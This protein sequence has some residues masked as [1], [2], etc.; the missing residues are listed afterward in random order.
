MTS[1]SS[2]LDIPSGG[3]KLGLFTNQI[4]KFIIL[5]LGCIF[6]VF[7]GVQV[8]DS[9]A[10]GLAILMRYVTAATFITA[11]ISPRLGIWLVLLMCPGLD[12][13]KR[14]LIL[15][16]N[17]N[18]FDVASVLAIAPVTMA[19]A[20]AGTF[21]NRIV[22][23]R[24]AAIPGEQTL[25]LILLA[26]TSLIV[27]SGVLHNLDSKLTLM[28]NL[29]EAC[30][31]LC[32]LLLIPVY[33]PKTEQVATLLRATVLIFIPVAFYGF[34]Q[35]FAGLSDFELRYLMSGLT[36]TAEDYMNSG[37]IFSSLNSNHSFSVTMAC[38]S[39]ISLLQRQLPAAGKWQGFMKRHGLL[40]FT[41]FCA[42]AIISLR[43]T[44]WLVVFFSL[45]GAI[46]FRTRLRTTVFYSLCLLGG[47]L[48]IFNAES[49]YGY[50]PRW[51]ASLQSSIPGYDQAF[52]LQT[53]NDRL[54]SFQTLTHSQNIWSPFGLSTEQREAI[55]VHDAISETLVSYG[56]IGLLAFVTVLVVVLGA[57]HRLV[58]KA[59]NPSDQYYA[60]L[61]L[62]FIFANLFVGA[63]MQSHINIF[64][65]NFIF[66]MCAGAL[67]KITFNQQTIV[68]VKPKIDP[69]ALAAAI[70]AAR[71]P[72]TA[73]VMGGYSL[74]NR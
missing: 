45:A 24:Q 25:F 52:Q 2:A 50:L 64:P 13:V 67:L 20:V 41:L 57:S 27:T 33:F 31:Y 18:M 62:S 1:T 61:L 21:F 36:V 37:R 71:R 14:F 16:S 74:P 48:I 46:C 39:V 26:I 43:R 49:I 23:R 70:K 38:C 65:V 51:E 6:S 29:A 15:F 59:T 63:I 42:A 17:V 72:V 55:F 19:G 5:G 44:G 60:S 73:T 9:D 68:A 3:S 7:I 40:L 66:W 35:K 4:I 53:F 30:I 28:R 10:N 54:S 11:M 22:F 34:Y 32:L 58:W 8:T 56:V 12:L 69:V 47:I